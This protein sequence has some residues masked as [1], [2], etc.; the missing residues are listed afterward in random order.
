[1]EFL[2]KEKLHQFCLAAVFNGNISMYMKRENALKFLHQKL[3][4]SIETFASMTLAKI[5]ILA[6][7]VA[8]MVATK[9]SK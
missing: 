8:F 2:L 9:Y 5:N 7:F 3:L 6:M 4:V 1:M